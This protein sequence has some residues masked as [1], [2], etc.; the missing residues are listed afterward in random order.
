MTDKKHNPPPHGVGEFS[1]SEKLVI[2]EARFY[3]SSSELIAWE[4]IGGQ[5]ETVGDALDL[6]AS[7]IGKGLSTRTVI[8]DFSQDGPGP[9]VDLGETAS[10]PG[11]P[12]DRPSICQKAFETR[13]SPGAGSWQL[14]LAGRPK[15]F[16]S[17]QG[18]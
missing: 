10:I 12:G 18:K 7:G 2:D 14:F 1:T 16:M 5:P 9:I 4:N 6:L 15:A 3:D 17:R 11:L 13:S 8:W